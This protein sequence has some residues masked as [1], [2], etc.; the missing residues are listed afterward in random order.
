MTQSAGTI[1]ARLGDVPGGPVHC[2]MSNPA[3]SRLCERLAAPPRT[4]Q[5]PPAWT[6]C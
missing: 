5:T 2:G 6:I 3:S 1:A 4:R